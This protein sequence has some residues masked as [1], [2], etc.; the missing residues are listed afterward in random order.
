MFIVENGD[1]VRFFIRS[2]LLGAFIS[3][4]YLLG[5]FFR[6]TAFRV[7]GVKAFFAAVRFLF[8]LIFCA[9]AAFLNILMVYS[10]NRGQVRLTAL[11]FEA[12]G[13]FLVYRLF[14]GRVYRLQDAILGFLART[15][16]AGAR[17]RIALIKEKR[18]K[19]RTLRTMLKYDSGADAAAERCAEAFVGRIALLIGYG[20]EK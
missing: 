15:V 14:A 6:K 7:F 11:L 4:L 9:F 12:L 20:G 18:Q 10:A 16:V 8:D 17:R 3:V 5:S 19:K 2:F 13:F 1:L